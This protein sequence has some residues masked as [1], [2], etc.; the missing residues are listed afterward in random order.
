MTFSAVGAFV[1]SGATTLSL[2]PAALGDF[3]LIE[4][5]N[6]SNATVS[7]TGLAS[8]NVRWSPLTA[9]FA[10][11]HQRADGA[12][13]HRHRHVHQYRDS[14][15][16]LVRDYPGGI[17]IAGHEFKS[18]AGANV[19]VLD[20][21]GHLDVGGTN[22]W[23]S[24]TPAQAGELYFGW[25]GDTGTA[26]AGSTTGYTY[27]NDSNGN[28]VAFNPACT[29]AAQAPVWADAGSNF[30][31][32]ILVREAA[33]GSPGRRDPGETPRAAREQLSRPGL[34]YVNS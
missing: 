3:F 8:T 5:N 32:M 16:F 18:T 20:V 27:G 22:T 26:T 1:S 2:T 33:P 28:G 11:T 31:V 34:I 19:I 10:G 21:Q 29:S 24:L 13:I 4:V 30:G 23:A 14:H 6:G 9:S 25:S 12:G 17:N 15:G 7:C